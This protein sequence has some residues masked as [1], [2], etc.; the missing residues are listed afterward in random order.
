MCIAIIV[1]WHKI[2][3]PNEC[4]F[5]GANSKKKYDLF[6]LYSDF[7]FNMTKVLVLPIYVQIIKWLWAIVCFTNLLSIVGPVNA[8]IV[9]CFQ[10]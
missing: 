10:K 2:V 8:Q 6:V 4:S 5:N 9:Q 3:K 1:Q 7:I